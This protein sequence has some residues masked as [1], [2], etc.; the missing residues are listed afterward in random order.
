MVIP[1]FVRQTLLGDPITV[2]GDGTQRRSF[3]WVGDVVQAII[4]LIQHPRAY[5]EVFNIGHTKEIS[6]HELAVLVK[7]MTQSAS[8]I[9]FV[10]YE[11]KQTKL[12]MEA[13]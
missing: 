13:R 4:T 8:E 9:V 10:P 1:R 6:I 7:E 5:G 3:T 11:Q 2:Y 12:Q